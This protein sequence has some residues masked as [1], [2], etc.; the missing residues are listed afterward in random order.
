VTAV[1]HPEVVA[2]LVVSGAPHPLAMRSAI[3]TGSGGQAR[4]SSYLLGFQVPWRPE[5]E[6]VKD[7]AALAV[8]LMRGWSGPGFPDTEVEQ[9][10]REAMRIPGVPHSSMEYFR[11]VVRSFFRPDGWRMARE[12]G[13]LVR[14]PTLQLQGIRDRCVLPS[15]AEASEQYVAAPYR[16]DVLPDVGHYPHQEDPATT[17]AALLDWLQTHSP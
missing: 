14:V 4:A 12:M 7:D 10:V 3:L 16:L 9:R 17:N 15:S 11:W 8:E 1:R 13:E 5:R 6:L 2:G